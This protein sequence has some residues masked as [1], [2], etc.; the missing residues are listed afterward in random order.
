MSSGAY[1]KVRLVRS[2]KRQTGKDYIDGIFT[3]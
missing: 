3:D 2:S 1:E